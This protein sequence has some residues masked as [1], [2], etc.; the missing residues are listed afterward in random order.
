MQLIIDNHKHRY[1]I[2]NIARMF[3]HDHKFT[4]DF[5]V[6]P[7]ENNYIVSGIRN[8]NLAYAVVN[9]D[10]RANYVQDEIPDNATDDEIE[11]LLCTLMY[12]ALCSVTRKTQPWGMLTGVRP[13]RLVHRMLDSGESIEN[14]R[15][16]F[17]NDYKI[18]DEKFRLL[19]QSASCER[20][21]IKSSNENDFSLYISIPFCPSRCSYCSFVSQ[22]VEKMDELTAPY[23]QKLIEEI[24]D[25]AKIV[26]KLNLNLKT[27]YIGGGTPTTLSA[28]ELLKLM[29]AVK[30]DFN[31]E[32]VIEYTVEAGRADTITKEKLEVIKTLGAD[33]ISINPQTFNDDVLVS[34]GRKHT[35][36][37][38][39][40]AYKMANEVGFKCI[41]MDLIAGLDGDSVDSFM[42][43]LQTAISLE[44]QNITVH[45]LTVKRAADLS[46][47]F[48]EVF[49]K[50]ENSV[51]TMVSACPKILALSGYHPYYMYRQKGTLSNLENVGYSKE[52]FDGYYN[53]F[54]MD[55][56]HSIIALGAGGVTKL[57]HPKTK[58][59]KRIYNYKF[60]IEYIRDFENII[61]RKQEVIE[62]YE[63]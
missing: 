15:N 61:N 29:S 25:A 35:A 38:V 17:I 42:S 2:E 14:I 59:I 22:S 49:K 46:E 34:I 6:D 48:E 32:T 7:S 41:N 8:G 21:I 39:L 36:Q 50:G 13:T 18:N 45:T 24:K 47:N 37:Q 52:G 55:E 56:I 54:I 10:R 31:L 43:S 16:K 3:F 1:E 51:D 4:V 23:I 62:F 5:D 20:E 53:V 30:E 58:E 12:R 44:P 11:W 63:K 9:I 60:P 27:V 33:R 28:N 19:Y 40:D 26:N 57:V